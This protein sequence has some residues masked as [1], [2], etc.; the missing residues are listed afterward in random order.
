MFFELHGRHVDI[1]SR[2][3]HNNMLTFETI[4]ATGVVPN[5]QN[6][7]VQIVNMEGKC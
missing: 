7:Y 6:H 5:Y 3:L 4:K 2:Q 1:C